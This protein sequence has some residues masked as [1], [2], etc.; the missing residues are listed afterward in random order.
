VIADDIRLPPDRKPA[1]QAAAK[2]DPD[3]PRITRENVNGWRFWARATEL[4]GQVMLGMDLFMDMLDQI[5]SGQ[6]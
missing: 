1:P 3:A 4:N 5:E 2:I 6:P